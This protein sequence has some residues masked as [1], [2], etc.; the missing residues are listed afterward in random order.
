F[1]MSAKKDGM[2]NMGGI[3]A[4]RE[5]ELSVKCKNM[6]IISEGFTTY[7]GLSGRDMEALA[8]GLQEVFDDDYLHYRIKSTAYLGE[9]LK[10]K[11]VPEVWPIGGHS[12]KVDD[13]TKYNNNPIH[14]YIG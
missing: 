13:K 12:T 4:V 5:E 14:E 10:D 11:G 6:L 3:L 8:I 7:G 2:V 1:V 9:R